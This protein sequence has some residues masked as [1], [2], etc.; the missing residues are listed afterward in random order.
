MFDIVPRD[1]VFDTVKAG[2]IRETNERVKCLHST[3]LNNSERNQK[4]FNDGWRGRPTSPYLD[5]ESPTSHFLNLLELELNK[6]SVIHLSI[7]IPHLDERRQD[8]ASTKATS[9]TRLCAEGRLVTG[10]KDQTFP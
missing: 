1:N 9:P 10:T 3:E 6:F 8:N 2:V 4:W 5:I 7:L